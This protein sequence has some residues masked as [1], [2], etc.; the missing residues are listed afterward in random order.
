M[1]ESIVLWSIIQ[2]WVAVQQNLGCMLA[3]LGS[4]GVRVERWAVA[5]REAA[6]G[7]MAV[8]GRMR[9][10]CKALAQEGKDRLETER[11]HEKKD[12]RN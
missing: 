7:T 6:E 11:S 9:P 3:G 5:G 12:E 1:A 10:G 2:S 8:R 4:L